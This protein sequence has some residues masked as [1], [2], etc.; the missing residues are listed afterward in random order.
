MDN[1][2]GGNNNNIDDDETHD[3]YEGVKDNDN[4]F[5]YNINHHSANYHVMEGPGTMIS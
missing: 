3:D 5:Y 4:Q 2:S 1:P